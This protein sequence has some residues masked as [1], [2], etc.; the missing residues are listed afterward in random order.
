MNVLATA[1]M[2]AIARIGLLGRTNRCRKEQ[3]TRQQHAVG[4]RAAPSE[5]PLL[6][7]HDRAATSGWLEPSAINHRPVHEA[8]RGAQINATSRRSRSYRSRGT[9]LPDPCP[10]H[11][12]KPYRRVIISAVRDTL[13]TP[14]P[15]RLAVAMSEPGLFPAMTARSA[16]LSRENTFVN[17]STE[18][19]PYGRLLLR[20]DG[21]QATGNRHGPRLHPVVAGSPDRQHLHGA[22]LLSPSLPSLG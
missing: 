21:V 19:K 7:N 1:R 3:V 14:R 2:S 16:R 5:R 13:D 4:S 8:V 20:G 12:T 10:S 6:S 18:G 11:S 22:D 17:R 9:R 15:A